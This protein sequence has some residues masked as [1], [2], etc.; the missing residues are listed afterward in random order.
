MGAARCCRP[1]R[2]DHPRIRGATAASVFAAAASFGSSP[3]TRGNSGAAY[4]NSASN[5]IIPAYAGQLR[6]S[7]SVEPFR[8][9]HPRI[10]GATTLTTGEKMEA[11]GS[12]PHTRGNCLHGRRL[13]HRIRIIP[14]YAGQ[15]AHLGEDAT[16]RPDHPRIRGATFEH[17]RWAYGGGGSSPHTR[18][19]C[20]RMPQLCLQRRIIPALISAA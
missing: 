10:R 2:S 9:D 16:R 4:L 18:G 20:T 14:A 8:A 6:A 5:R 17:A 3:H 19:N 11:G 12:S 15:L 13:R 7:R 1:R